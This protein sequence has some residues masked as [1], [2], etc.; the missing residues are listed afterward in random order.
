MK[1]L[2]LAGEDIAEALVSFLLVAL[3]EIGYPLDLSYLEGVGGETDGK[4]WF[5]FADGQFTSFE[6]CQAG[7]RASL[8]TYHTLRKCAGLSFDEQATK[9]GK[10]RALRLLKAFLTEKTEERYA[11]LGDFIRMYG[12]E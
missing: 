2:C 7:E 3:R 9:G 5:D 1:A 10:K 4:L 8:S 11:A 6:R 12:D